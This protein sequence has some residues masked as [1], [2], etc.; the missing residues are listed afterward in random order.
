M[1]G[2]AFSKEDFR[3]IQWSVAILVLFALLGAGV[4]FG[5]LQL[6]KAAQAEA[7]KVEAE[8]G[9]ARSKL[10]R[11]RDEEQEIR[12]KIARYQD[13][14][15]R[16]YVTEEQRLEW[17]ERIAQIK[18]ARKLLDV[19]YELMPQKP[20]DAALLP[21]GAT[22]GGYEFMS[23]KMKLQMQ[24]LHEEDLLGFLNDLRARVRAMIVVRKCLVER[25]PRSGGGERGT[26]PQLKAECDLDW[27]TLRE[28][29]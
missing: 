15:A 20:V 22:G 14:V 19:Q 5:S 28:K 21:D 27:I 29:K 8:R 25:I 24:L 7:R 1:S 23:S 11:A 10:A 26:Q 16:G 13:L 3:R 18:T 12:A 17:I 2:A 9:E 4:V 6:T